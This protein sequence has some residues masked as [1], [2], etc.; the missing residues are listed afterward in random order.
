MPGEGYVS[1]EEAA[2]EPGPSRSRSAGPGGPKP[3]EPRHVRVRLG[4][5]RDSY[6]TAG[7]GAGGSCLEEEGGMAK[8]SA[9]ESAAE[10]TGESRMGVL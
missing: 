7:D 3:R 8:E 10:K 2:S 1:G 5:S 9:A 6:P 4:G